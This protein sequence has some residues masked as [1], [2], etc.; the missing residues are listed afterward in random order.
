MQARIDELRASFKTALAAA[1]DADSL[2][3]LRV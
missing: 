2:E 1:T 3:S